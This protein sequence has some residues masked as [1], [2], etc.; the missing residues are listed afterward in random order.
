[1]SVRLPVQRGG[2]PVGRRHPVQVEEALDG[3]EALE[4][5]LPH[6]RSHLRDNPRFPTH[7]YARKLRCK[8]I[9]IHI[10]GALHELLK[11]QS[12]LK[13]IRLVPS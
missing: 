13:I 7:L 12:E 11:S 2:G 6:L 4:Q 5:S 3:A 8:A 9:I 10:F 1:M